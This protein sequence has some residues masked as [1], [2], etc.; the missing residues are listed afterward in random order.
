MLICVTLMC[1][2]AHAAEPSITVPVNLVDEKGVVAS[3]GDIVISETPYGLLFSPALSGL[4]AGLHGFH[5][6]ENGSCDPGQKDGKAVAALAAGGHWDPT[7]S[8]RHAGPYGD[9]H[10][11]DLPALYVGADGKAS[12][13]ALAPRLHGL[14][15]LRGHAL[16]LHAGGD[17]HDDHPMPLGG[18]GARLACGVI[19]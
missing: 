1:S 11:G 9:G 4:P 18:G 10:M 13:P 8:G 6:H 5:V 16:M 19:K 12:Y 3:A 14:D 2:A 15:S 17:N 7:K